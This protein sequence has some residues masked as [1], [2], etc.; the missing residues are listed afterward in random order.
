M[1]GVLNPPLMKR[2]SSLSVR[3]SYSDNQL[4]LYLHTATYLYSRRDAYIDVEFAGALEEFQEQN[5]RAK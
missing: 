1:E 4:S 5:A 3:S 2:S